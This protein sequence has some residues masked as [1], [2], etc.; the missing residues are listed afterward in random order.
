MVSSKLN[1]SNKR[2]KLTVKNILYNSLFLILILLLGFVLK[3]NL[4]D[5]NLSDSIVDENYNV[6][7]GSISDAQNINF[8]T[9]LFYFYIGVLVPLFFLLCYDLVYFFVSIEDFKDFFRKH[10]IN[11]FF[12]IISLDMLFILL[13]HLVGLF[14]ISSLYLFIAF[15]LIRFVIIQI[16]SKSLRSVNNWFINKKIPL[17]IL[18]SL[19]LYYFV[20]S[21]VFFI[22]YSIF[23]GVMMFFVFLGTYFLFL[24]IVD[25]FRVSA[26]K[27]GKK[28]GRK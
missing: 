11:I 12:M 5:A 9:E 15:I 6:D 10:N 25:Y 28:G 4:A 8:Q 18:E 22:S 26:M 7:T 3:P 23:F 16:S 24:F 21:S 13:L 19:I 14:S 1:N 27:S 17:I 20:L 2:Y